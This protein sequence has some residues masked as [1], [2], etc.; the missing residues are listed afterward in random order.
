MRDVRASEDMIDIDRILLELEK[1]PEYKNQIMLQS[2]AGISDP[3]VGI[4]RTTEFDYEEKDFCTP[5]FDLP[6]TNEVIR[7]LNMFRTRVMRMKKQTCYTYHSDKTPRIH[8]PIVTHENCF[9]VYEDRVVRC[10]ANGDTYYVD[11]TKRHTFVNASI[12][13][14]IHIV[15]CVGEQYQNQCQISIT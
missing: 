15:G 12:H 1:L 8:I 2:P 11:T 3:F 6:Y 14:R 13:D 4:G 10:P 7:S 9:F 5:T